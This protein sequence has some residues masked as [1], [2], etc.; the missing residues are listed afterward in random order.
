WS[1]TGTVRRN[2][3]HG[4]P[5]VAW[6]CSRDLLTSMLS[7]TKRQT[8]D[9]QRANK[10]NQRGCAFVQSLQRDA[11]FQHR[12]L[13]GLGFGSSSFAGERA[14]RKAL[15][16]AAALPPKPET[17]AI[18]STVATRRRWTEP[19]FLSRAALRCWPIPGNSSRI[20]SEI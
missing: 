5:T 1:F 13:P 20:L 3:G 4:P 16:S 10:P 8:L 19:N 7:S 11:D 18:C 14:M 17:S 12:A 6:Q 2:N 15:S 9:T